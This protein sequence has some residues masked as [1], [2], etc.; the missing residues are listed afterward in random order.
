MANL[1]P[2]NTVTSE[3]LLTET[4]DDWASKGWVE[5]TD[6]EDSTNWG[7]NGHFADFGLLSP[8]PAK[9]DQLVR[10][11]SGFPPNTLVR[12]A[13]QMDWDLGVG[14]PGGP[15]PLIDG[16][17]FGGWINDSFQQLPGPVFF[18]D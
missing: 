10:T 18:S 9:H 2:W 11:L 3:V 15:G 7:A 17:L 16:L 6:I 4:F 5:D 13:I 8:P 12:I 14:A 1:T